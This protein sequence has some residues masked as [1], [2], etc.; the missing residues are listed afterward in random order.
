MSM[1]CTNDVIFN[2]MLHAK[3]DKFVNL[4]KFVEVQALRSYLKWLQYSTVNN[5]SMS[6]SLDG[7]SFFLFLLRVMCKLGN[8]STETVMMHHS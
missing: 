5:L 2:L 8:L 4:N 1:M 6:M 7:Q 3:C